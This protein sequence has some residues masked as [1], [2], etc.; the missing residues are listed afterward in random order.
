MVSFYDYIIESI[1]D[2]GILKSAFMA[3]SPLAGKSYILSKIKSGQ[4]E[5]RIVNTDKLYPLFKKEWQ[6]EWKKISPKVKTITKNQLLLYLNSMLPLAIDGT[7]SNNSSLLRRVGLLKSLG[8]DADAMIFVN[9]K[10]EVAIERLKKRERKVDIDFLKRAYNRIQETKNYYKNSFKIFIEI[11]NN[12]PI[13]DKIITKA[14][15]KLSNYYMSP[16]YNPIG[17][18]IIRKM[19][20]NKLKYLIP[21]IYEKDFLHKIINIWY[22]K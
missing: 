22:E 2:K 21:D 17:Q 16:V 4:I 3:G 20:E 7:S 8:Y 15:N 12:G 13:N 18:N 10:L 9:T 6:K 5:P 19:K 14:F 1:E 11:E